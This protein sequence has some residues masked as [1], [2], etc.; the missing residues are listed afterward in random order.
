M[1]LMEKEKTRTKGRRIP[2]KL[3][4]KWSSKRF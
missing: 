4:S 1:D 3:C 2:K